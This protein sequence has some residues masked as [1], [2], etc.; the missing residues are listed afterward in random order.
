[1][2]D[3]VSFMP[4]AMLLGPLTLHRETS[5]IAKNGGGVYAVP[6]ARSCYPGDLRAYALSIRSKRGNDVGGHF[7]PVAGCNSDIGRAIYVRQGEQEFGYPHN[8]LALGRGISNVK[9]GIDPDP[10]L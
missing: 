1:M 7:N 10:R 3:R 4:D 6:I 2:I 5:V 9:G 8:G